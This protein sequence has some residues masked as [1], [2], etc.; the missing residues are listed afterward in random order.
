[1]HPLQTP[2]MPGAYELTPYQNT[3]WKF[4]LF[5]LL[6]CFLLV[7]AITFPLFLLVGTLPDGVMSTLTL[8]VATLFLG[9]VDVLV[10]G[11]VC[12]SLS[13]E[14]RT[15]GPLF[16][17]ASCLLLLTVLICSWW[18]TVDL[19]VVWL[20]RSALLFVSLFLVTYIGAVRAD[21][22]TRKSIRTFL[23]AISENRVLIG[24]PFT[25]RY[26]LS[27]QQV[28]SIK[29]LR[30]NLTYEQYAGT[31]SYGHAQYNKHSLLVHQR[32]DFVGEPA[33]PLLEEFQWAVP[34]HLS[35]FS[36]ARQNWRLTVLIKPRKG[37]RMYASYPLTMI[38]TRPASDEK[39]SHSHPAFPL[40]TT[41]SSL[42][43]ETRDILRK[44]LLQKGRECLKRYDGAKALEAYEELIHLNPLDAEGIAFAYLQ[45]SL[46]L[47]ALR[48]LKEARE[49]LVEARRHHADPIHL[50]LTE[51]S[52]LR[53]KVW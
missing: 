33:N 37:S 12:V 23:L 28:T 11:A 35:I 51:C 36:Q 46:A 1:M 9:A 47:I 52:L 29:T 38:S 27:F 2:N 41:T 20:G 32:S 50:F 8:W 4:L 10:V 6:G 45:T 7:T 48:R 19:P 5:V 49:A 24:T 14:K 15:Q 18:W 53:R 39:R 26:Q 31:D 16:F 3:S 13:G 22:R 34:A 40:A 17:G 25:I 44:E 21:R 42:S 43:S 30:I